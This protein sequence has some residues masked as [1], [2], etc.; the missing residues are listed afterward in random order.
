MA[1]QPLN[2]PAE[3]LLITKGGYYLLNFFIARW[4]KQGVQL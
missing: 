3:T 1:E 4:V 2:N